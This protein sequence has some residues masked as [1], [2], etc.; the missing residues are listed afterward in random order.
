MKQE[1]NNR[2]EAYFGQQKL[3]KFHHVYMFVDERRDR[4]KDILILVLVAV[5]RILLCL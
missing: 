1:T 5:W 3:R 2:N 4:L